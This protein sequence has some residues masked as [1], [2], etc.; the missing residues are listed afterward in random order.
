MIVLWDFGFFLYRHVIF[1][2]QLT[3]LYMPDKTVIK[4]LFY[5][6]WFSNGWISSLACSLSQRM[7]SITF[8]SG[9][10]KHYW[11]YRYWSVIRRRS[12]SLRWVI[13]IRRVRST[14]SAFISNK[15]ARIRMASDPTTEI[16]YHFFK[17]KLR[18]AGTLT[19]IWL[20]STAVDNVY[21]SFLVDEAQILWWWISGEMVPS[22]L[23]E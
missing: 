21:A 7:W 9:S 10:I 4:K 8:N 1:L 14:M 3:Y 20:S 19:D 22:T 17:Y 5:S 12:F 15:S 11:F 6:G 23:P 16:T 18:H 13:V 2:T